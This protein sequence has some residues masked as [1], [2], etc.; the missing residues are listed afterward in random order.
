M[1]EASLEQ[2]KA[3]EVHARNALSYTEVKSPANGAVGTIPYR[4]GALVSSTSAQPLTTVS[5][6]SEMYVYFSMSE[7]QLQS[8]V[9]RYGLYP[10]DGGADARREVA[11]KRWFRI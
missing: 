7:Q 11:V 9:R 1:A 2:A 5:D 4:V 10:K 6:N 8:L 3:Q